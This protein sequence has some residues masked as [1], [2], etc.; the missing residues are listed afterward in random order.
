MPSCPSDSELA[1][2]LNES[3]PAERSR[4]VA[5]HID[6]CSACQ[7]RLDKL[8]TDTAGPI[9]RYKELPPS[10]FT[11]AAEPDPAGTV[12]AGR[13][14]AARLSG[15]PR[16]PGFEVQAE[17]G[18]GSSGVVYRA[19]HKRLN[20]LVALKLI[21]AGSTA[22]ACTL[23]QFFTDVGVIAH[24]RHPQ[25]ARVFE[26]DTYAGPEGVSIPYLA[27]ELL[28]GGS[29]TQ[30]LQQTPVKPRE[31]AEL[32]EPVA[33]ALHT[34][35]LKGVMHGNLKPDNFLFATPGGTL[36]VT[37]FGLARLAPSGAILTET[38]EVFGL[39][40]Y[41]APEQAAGAISPAADV[42]SLG[43]ILAECFSGQSVQQHRHGF[44]QAI[45]P[46]LE[47]IAQRCLHKDPEQRYPTTEELADEVRRFLNSRSR[48]VHPT[49]WHQRLWLWMKRW[50]RPS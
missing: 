21:L 38:G 30:R 40:P 33:R 7:V 41:L 50:K 46:N 39:S 25:I 44:L 43:A 10:L 36:K 2:F 32:I 11:L 19:R 3:L 12:V 13:N 31:A 29:L 23:K 28:E 47:A 42:Y 15:L 5:V 9:A 17:L 26:A 16:V 14:R 34:A 48:A 1:G 35:H 4:R 49:R 6:R 20:R 24:L 22:D 37:D 45:S 27:T 18:R 8:T